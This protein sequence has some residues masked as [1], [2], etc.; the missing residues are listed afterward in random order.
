MIILGERPIVIGS[1]NFGFLICYIKIIIHAIKEIFCR[2]EGKYYPGHKRVSEEILEGLSEM[3]VS[4][5]LDPFLLK[6]D[7]P[8]LLLSHPQWLHKLVLRQRKRKSVNKIICGPNVFHSLMSGYADS[9]KELNA[10]ILTP[11]NWVAANYKKQA[12]ELEQQI[13]VWPCGVDENE[14][15]PVSNSLSYNYIVIY[16]KQDD[17][18]DAFIASILSYLRENN[19]KV[20]IVEYG[21]YSINDWK[22]QLNSAICVVYLTSFTESQGIAQFEAWSMDVPIFV[23]RVTQCV[24]DGWDYSGA[25]SSPYLDRQ[26]GAFWSNLSCLLKL[27][28]DL[29]NKNKEYSPRR[30]ILENHTRRLKTEELI[31]YMS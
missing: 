17:F 13:K 15:I 21:Q 20:V 2:E 14:W 16:R 22:A 11:S 23:Y 3:G 9:L 28:S 19:I 31:G 7:S 25:N 24:V 6:S 8:V 26:S 5:A 18:D 4:Y 1:V 12:I 10:T 30:Y 27:L 29:L